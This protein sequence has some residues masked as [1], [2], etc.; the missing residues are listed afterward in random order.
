MFEVL[1]IK[2]IHHGNVFYGEVK[3]FPSEGITPDEWNTMMHG[4][5]AETFDEC[6]EALIVDVKRFRE[7]KI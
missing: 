5:K 1:S 2:V 7:K 4:A 6:I 3:H